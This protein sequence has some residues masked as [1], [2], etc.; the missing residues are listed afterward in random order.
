LTI[1]LWDVERSGVAM[2]FSPTTIL[3]AYNA[4]GYST[5]LAVIAPNNPNLGSPPSVLFDQQGNIA[6]VSSPY[7]NGGR[8][9]ANGADLGLQYNIDTSYGTFSL[10]SRWTYLNEFVIN[11]P[12]NRPYQVAGSSSSEWY[13]GSFF[14]DATNPQAWLKWRGDT[15]LDWTWHNWDVNWTWHFLDG[16]H[17][18][19]FAQQLDGFFK[20]HFVHPTNFIDAQVS[21]TQIFTPPVEAAPV[22][23]YSK[24]K[25][26]VA[27][28]GKE[29]PV[30]A[31]LPCWKSILNN[32]TLTV[33]ASNLFDKEPPFARS[34]DF[35]NSIGYP[36]GLYDNIGRFC[37]V[38]LVKK[39]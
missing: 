13:V 20:E 10:L 31:A 25:E 19:F 35:S 8:V 33:G 18:Q 4:S 27:D 29:A 2:F 28:K 36:G 16:Y 26:V 12:G 30:A 3:N 17:E 15:T 9:R 22:A 21:Y 37:Y 38:R 23:G 11:Y 6:G 5:S 1:D 7:T 34:I 24:G 32:T 39:F 14:G